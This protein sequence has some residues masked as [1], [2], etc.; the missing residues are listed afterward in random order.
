MSINVG[1]EISPSPDREISAPT[2]ITD[3]KKRELPQSLRTV[4]EC[5]ERKSVVFTL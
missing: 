4:L 2:F 5:V 3:K 1:A